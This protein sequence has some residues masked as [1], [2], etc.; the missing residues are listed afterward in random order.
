MSNDSPD[1]SAPS[2]SVQI[3]LYGHGHE[4]LNTLVGSLGRA[5][6]TAHEH[7]LIGDVAVLIGDSSPE[8]VLS[9]AQA[10]S[11]QSRLGG[12]GVRRFDYAFFN[13]N[14]GS[15]GGNN[16]LFERSESDMVFIIN[17]DCY[18]EPRLLC[19]LIGALDDKS[20]GIV[21]GRQVPL[22]HPK[23]FDRRTGD[24]S[25]AS[26]ACMLVRRE[27]IR[28]TEGFDEKS[29]FMYCDDVDFSWRARLGGY[30][31]VYQPTACVYHDKRLNQDGQVEA[32]DAEVYF[33]AEAALMMAWKYSRPDLVDQW[34]TGLLA[35]G[36]P[37]HR[38]AVK[39]FV[40]RRAHD[41]LPAPRDPEG[42]VAQF[43]GYNYAA[44][45]F[46]YDD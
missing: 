42:L 38:Q 6:V 27:V 10:R 11:L 8:P 21:E 24:T 12:D 45:R 44:H 41:L 29:F 7:R 33:S 22:E 14:R 40:E 31:V 2:L 32:G 26:G 25:W 3:V 17:P 30:R 1:R 39:N 13:Q 15:A 46:G 43:V 28:L 36:L 35:T 23:E 37:A 34:S 5:V 18:A 9:D 4:S 20:V 19:E 16:D